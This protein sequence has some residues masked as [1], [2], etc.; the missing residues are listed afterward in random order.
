MSTTEWVVLAIA[1]ALVAID[2]IVQVVGVRLRAKSDRLE[3][4]LSSKSRAL[5]DYR[6]RNREFLEMAERF[7]VLSNQL[8][9][10]LCT[11]IEDRVDQ[12]MNRRMTI[13]MRALFPEA[14][15]QDAS[16]MEAVQRALDQWRDKYLADVRLAM[17]TKQRRGRA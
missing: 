4:E 1:I 8:S 2:V 15:P 16:D 9:E 12:F 7:S 5:D 14:I 11:R 3:S 6:E 17:A 10:L 13:A